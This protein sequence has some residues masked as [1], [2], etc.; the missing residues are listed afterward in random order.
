MPLQAPPKRKTHPI[1]WVAF[2]AHVGFAFYYIRQLSL[3]P[4]PVAVQF[5]SALLWPGLAVM[6]ENT[7]DSPITFV[8]TLTRPA[9][10]VT[11][12]LALHPG[13]QDNEH[14]FTGWLVGEHGDQIALKNNSYKT[15]TGF[16]PW[17]QNGS[18]PT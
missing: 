9:T 2:F 6:F 7:S 10:N 8:A 12:S 5:R 17:I 15:W 1:T 18:P 13:P 11:K 16:I 3:P 4:I 14:S